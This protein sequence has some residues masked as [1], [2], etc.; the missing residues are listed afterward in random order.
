[1]EI[2]A[3][4]FIDT[5]EIGIQKSTFGG[6]KPLKPADRC[7]VVMCSRINHAVF[8]IAVRQIDAAA[9]RFESEMQHLQ[10]GK[11]RRMEQFK[12]RR[13]QIAQIFGNQWQITQCIFELAKK[14]DARTGNPLSCRSVLCVSRYRIVGFERAEVIDAHII[15]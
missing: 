13:R 9:I 5:I 2:V 7:V 1:M 11:A 12:D 15:T 6:T 10:A 14:V 8:L 4:L 3:A